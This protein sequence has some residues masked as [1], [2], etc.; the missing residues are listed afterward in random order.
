MRCGVGRVRCVGRYDT[1]RNQA[2]PGDDYCRS[3]RE[4]IGPGP[5]HDL[6]ERH[7][8]GDGRVPCPHCDD[9]VFDSD[10]YGAPCEHCPAGRAA[11]AAEE[12][13]AFG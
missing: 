8:W 5:D 1:C 13:S 12:R 3:C 9:K 7:G 11:R 6:L 2:A 10:G 4:A